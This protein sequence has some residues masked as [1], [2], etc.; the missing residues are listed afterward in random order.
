MQDGCKVYMGSSMA[1]NGSCFMVTWTILQKPLL[2]G[3]PNTKPGDHALVEN[4]VKKNCS[5]FPIAVLLT[6]L[7][8][9]LENDCR[10][11]FGFTT[12]NLRTANFQ[13]ADHGGQKNR[14][15]KTTTVLFLSWF[16][17]VMAL[18]MLTTVDLL[19]FIM[20]EDPHEEFLETIFG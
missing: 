19:Y 12:A 4:M 16:L 7:I 5:R 3:R 6:T 18:R 15:G 11:F 9:S 17:L 13:T 14:N 2:G 1:S 20:C 8:Y 10:F